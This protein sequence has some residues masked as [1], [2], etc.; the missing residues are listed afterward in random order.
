MYTQYL[1]GGFVCHQVKQL[2]A[3]HSVCNTSKRGRERERWEKRVI[4][5]YLPVPESSHTDKVGPAPT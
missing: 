4:R 5:R 1:C 3:T 2:I